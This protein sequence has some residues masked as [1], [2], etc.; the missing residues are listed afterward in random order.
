MMTYMESNEYF[1]EMAD[2]IHSLEAQ[3]LVV[4]A[5]TEEGASLVRERDRLI[6]VYSEE[7]SEAHRE[8]QRY[9]S[10]YGYCG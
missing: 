6:D 9:G 8:S 3:I 2:R 10:G 7:A 5:T 1:Y 4:G